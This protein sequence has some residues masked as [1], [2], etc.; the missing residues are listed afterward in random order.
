MIITEHATNRSE[1][2]NYIEKLKVN[3]SKRIFSPDEVEYLADNYSFEAVEFRQEN[4]TD[5]E[6]LRL[7]STWLH[8]R[9]KKLGHVDYYVLFYLRTGEHLTKDQFEFMERNVAECFDISHG[10][11]YEINDRFRFRLRIRLICSYKRG[12]RRLTRKDW[13]NGMDIEIRI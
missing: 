9:S 10:W 12:I 13:R 8:E 2:R 1:F 3:N 11:L 5:E 7:F 4:E 6:F